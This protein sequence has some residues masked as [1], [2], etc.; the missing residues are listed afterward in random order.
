MALRSRQEGRPRAASKRSHAG[1]RVPVEHHGSP[2][3]WT[4]VR[5]GLGRVTP[6]RSTTVRRGLE[7]TDT[8]EI[9]EHEDL[10]ALVVD[11]PT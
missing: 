8:L 7:P 10:A 2:W 9:G 11:A 4:T 1:E 5:R 6:T 3:W